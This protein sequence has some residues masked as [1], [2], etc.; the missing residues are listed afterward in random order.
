[1]SCW[2]EGRSLKPAWPGCLRRSFARTWGPW[3]AQITKVRAV[4]HAGLQDLAIT[5]QCSS[6]GDE[7]GN[8]PLK[9]LSRF[10]TSQ[11]HKVRPVTLRNQI[12]DRSISLV[13]S[14]ITI[15]RSITLPYPI[16][17][18]PSFNVPD[19]DLKSRPFDRREIPSQP[20]LRLVSS[21]SL[22]IS[23]RDRQSRERRLEPGHPYNMLA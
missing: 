17:A 18:S 13:F 8:D 1:M 23:A 11:T 14:F 20:V 3:M 21:H 4:V 9:P 15:D 16:S 10:E 5:T 12:L 7:R 19:Y 22:P 6:S 2:G